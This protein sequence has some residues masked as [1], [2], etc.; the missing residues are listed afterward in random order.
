MADKLVFDVHDAVR[1]LPGSANARAMIVGTALDYL[2]SS[3]DS[4]RGDG[5]AEKALAKAYRRLGDVQG[6]IRAGSLGDPSGALARYRQAVTL[7]DDAI[8]RAPT[9]VD[10]ISER[11]VL[12]DR[13][14]TLHAFTGQLRDAVQTTE[15]GI[16]FGRPFLASNDAGLRLSMSDLYLD[17]ADARRNMN[18]YPAALRDALEALHLAEAV[19]ADRPSDPAAT[20]AVANAYAAAGM[21]ESGLN[22]LQD[23]LAHFQKG[24]AAMES[25]A[26]SDVRNASWN[27]DLM[28]A[29]G[30]VGDTLGSPCLQNLG[31]RAGALQ[32]YSKAAAVGKRLYEADRADQRAA[33]DYGIALNRVETLMDDRDLSAKLA[34]QLESVRVLEDAARIGPANVP[35]EVSLA[36][37]HQHLGDSH[38]AAGSAGAA[39]DAYVRSAEIAS[40]GMQP[41]HAALHILSIQ[42]NQRLAANAVLRGRRAEAIDYAR[43]ALQAG[44]NPPP[45]SGNLRALPRGLAAM[46]L[47]YA[48]LQRSRVGTASDRQDA[49][50]WLTRSLDSWHASQSEP[51]FGEPHRR[52]MHEV[53]MALARAQSPARPMRGR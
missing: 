52:E 45:D 24:T 30:H 39:H 28:L 36:L 43:R 38:T 46:G 4:V 15:E 53:E 14:G 12:Y 8:R 32:A 41:G 49:V 26:A 27:R 51:G 2:D 7:L 5:N 11:L 35:L 3:V 42:A 37:A 21:A 13:V 16:R 40:S 31:D 9:D 1:D 29:Y 17:S 20:H 10:G 19:V 44:E 22:R 6:N 33:A 25:L 47:T 50:S 18:D 34:M 23:A 48:A